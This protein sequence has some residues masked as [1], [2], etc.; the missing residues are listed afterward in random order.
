MKYD[1]SVIICGKLYRTGEEVPDYVKPAK[2]SIEPV[3]SINRVEVEAGSIGPAFPY[4]KTD[5]NRMPTGDLQKLAKRYE[6]PKAYNTSGQE[7]K[8]IIIEKFNL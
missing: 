3:T 8:R 2:Q 6:I 4:T 7:L 5:I 1:H